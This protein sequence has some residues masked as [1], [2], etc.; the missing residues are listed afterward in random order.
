ME[1]CVIVL[2]GTSMDNSESLKFLQHEENLD[3]VSLS[4][5]EKTKTIS[6]FT[7]SMESQKQLLS[8]VMIKG[9]RKDG[10]EKYVN[11]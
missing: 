5:R 1:M 10:R 9:Y 6:I 2:K 8:R 3:E 7:I 11:V 4:G